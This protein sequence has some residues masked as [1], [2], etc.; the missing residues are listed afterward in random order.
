MSHNHVLQRARYSHN[1]FSPDVGNPHVNVLLFITAYF[2]Y[3]FIHMMSLTLLRITQVP[4]YDE[5]NIFISQNIPGSPWLSACSI[6]MCMISQTLLQNLRRR[7]NEHEH[8]L[9]IYI[10][11]I[12]NIT[13]K[14]SQV[15]H[16]NMH[17][18]FISQEY[19]LLFITEHI[20]YM[21]K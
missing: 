2:V 15:P 3:I 9:C 12:T 14:I 10:Y 7:H 20:L 18:I 1:F 8:S 4:R 11:H 17:D 13:P 5:H 6:Y 16:Y 19:T 21:C